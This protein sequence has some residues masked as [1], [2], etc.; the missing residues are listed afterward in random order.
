[1]V[2]TS[3]ATVC[4]FDPPQAWL[5]DAGVSSNPR[6]QP[7]LHL[8][9]GPIDLIIA[10][11]GSPTEV[12]K[13]YRQATLA[14]HDVLSVLAAQLPELR[15]PLLDD[16][17]RTVNGDVAARMVAACRPFY[18]YQ[19]TPMIAVAGSVA[20]YICNAMLAGRCL[21][22]VQVN[23]GG[24]I[25]LSLNAGSSCLIGINTSLQS[26]THVDTITIHPDENIGGVATSG[27]QGR[28]H[29][30]GIADA[31]TVLA[32]NC[33]SAD[34]AATL[35]A[36]AVNLPN[37]K[38]ITRRPAMSLSPDSDLGNRLVTV[39]VAVLTTSERAQ[40]LEAGSRLATCFCDAGLVQAVYL[41]LQGQSRVVTS[42]SLD[43]ANLTHKSNRACVK[44]CQVATSNNHF[45]H[46][47]PT[48][49]A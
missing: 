4:A 40:A 13:A 39:D 8:Q 14:F 32:P 45:Q 12:R 20:D 27:W 15:K 25:A 44:H 35:V 31:V 19:L 24:D 46:M 16:G 3:V 49:T 11:E 10:A 1:M 47:S 9:Q 30:L 23:N 2:C 21:Q 29:S 18:A 28:S 33:A 38:K 37:S 34:T 5:L 41:H 6:L 26:T 22:K 43:V 48:L 7:R 17:P 42:P 36:N